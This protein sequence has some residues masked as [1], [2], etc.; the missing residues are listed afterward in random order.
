VEVQT[1]GVQFIPI[2]LLY[3]LP[4]TQKERNKIFPITSNV[5][6]PFFNLSSWLLNELRHIEVMGGFNVSNSIDFNQ[7]VQDIGILEKFSK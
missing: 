2:P 6:S 3:G 5:D 4:Q 7:K 1:E